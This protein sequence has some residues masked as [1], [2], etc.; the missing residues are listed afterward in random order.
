MDDTTGYITKIARA[1]DMEADKIPIVIAG[2]KCDLR[3][4]S[5]DKKN[6]VDKDDARKL[7]EGKNYKYF[8]TSA[9][10]KINNET[11]FLEVVR[12]IWRKNEQESKGKKK[13]KG[14]LCS[15]L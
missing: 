13:K 5:T 1:K 9:K 14:K 15:I 3:S 10:N 11:C 4:E 12:E 7:V 2:N 8:E 6:H